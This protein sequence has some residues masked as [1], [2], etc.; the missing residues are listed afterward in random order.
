M[1][2]FDLLPSVSVFTKK[3]SVLKD[4]HIHNIG[5]HNFN[6][7]KPL[8]N[9]RSQPLHTI[10]FVLDGE[11]FLQVNGKSYNLKKGDVFYLAPITP[12]VYYP[13][14]KKPW[15]YAWVAVDGEKS[16]DYFS[17]YSLSKNSV[18]HLKKFEHI[19]RF[20]YDF[21]INTPNKILQEEKMFSVFFNLMS[22]ILEEFPTPQSEQSLAE[23]YV[24]DIQDTIYCN[25]TNPKFKV[26]DISSMVHLSYP[27]VIKIFKQ[28]LNVPIK[29]Y[30]YTMRL[31]HALNLLLTSE[32]SITEIAFKSG[33]S[34]PL[35][36]STA[37]KKQF[38]IPPNEY[39][40]QNKRQV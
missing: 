40:K 33:F 10:H 7:V 24:K 2:N 21:F 18:Y 29:K 9:V 8:F 25:F 38:K 13:S 32:Y 35:Y 4:F 12:Y 26:E 30:L 3:N 28:S 5:F 34:D 6:Q 31:D 11:G 36:F 22:M 16:A 37:F 39:R 14:Q 19:H 23:Q 27:Y 20:I 15:K 1:L 17:R